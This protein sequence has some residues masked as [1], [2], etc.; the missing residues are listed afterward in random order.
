MSYQ[1]LPDYPQKGGYPAQQQQQGPYPVQ[2]TPVQPGYG[3]PPVHNF[4]PAATQQQAYSP[5]AHM[6][7]GNPNYAPN[8]GVQN[9]GIVMPVPPGAM[10]GGYWTRGSYCGGLS[11]AV[12]IC[13]MFPCIAMCPVDNRDVYVAPNG[14]TYDHQGNVVDAPR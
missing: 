4:H 6:Q 14:M 1:P 12:G 7:P 8:L 3:Q 2:G 10:P 9:P 13:C 5:H 11:W